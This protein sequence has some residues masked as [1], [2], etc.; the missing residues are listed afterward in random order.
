MSVME[1]KKFREERNRF[2]EK[3]YRR[4]EKVMGVNETEETVY[5]NEELDI[6]GTAEQ[7]YKEVRNGYRSRIEEIDK[8][9]DI[10]KK[11][12]QEMK[13]EFCLYKIEELTAQPEEGVVNIAGIKMDYLLHLMENTGLKYPYFRV[14]DVEM[15]D[16]I[17]GVIEEDTDGRINI[18]LENH[19]NNT[20]TVNS[21]SMQEF[22]NM[23]QDDFEKI[24]GEMNFYA[25]GQER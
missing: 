10:L 18:I 4:E 15:G 9:A 3:F 12:G 1:A 13:Y 8:I 16:N 20:G 2:L 17:S 19:N 5:T 21:I 25:I 24:I 6:D 7:L 22:L 23:T 11:E 14:E